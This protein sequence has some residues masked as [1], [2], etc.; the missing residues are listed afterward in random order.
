MARA[1]LNPAVISH[2]LSPTERS[3]AYFLRG[4]S[5]QAQ[6]LFV[7]AATDYAN[8]LEFNPDNSAALY[9]MGGLHQ[10][11]PRLAK[12]PQLVLQLFLRAAEQGHPGAALFVGNA[13]L[14]G[15]G[16][17]KDLQL[18]RNWLTTAAQA[19]VRSAKTLLASTYR[20]AHTETPNPE[21]ARYWYGQA[22]E[23][24]DADA[25]LALG[26]MIRNREVDDVPASAS[27]DYFQR[28]AE[29]GSGTAMT[30]LAHAYMTGRD[31]DEDY[32]KA[33]SWYRKAVKLDAA[34]Q[35]RRFGLHS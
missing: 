23:E 6:G 35:F 10:I 34:G 25:L 33:R 11:E 8:A 27:L 18:A 16:T 29:R 22:I 7:S 20:P 19:G 14:N 5:F 24:G 4:H 21:Q 1:Y 32:A 30:V 26:F 9:A 2:R 12:N 3:G 17:E 28:A 15:E 13:Y 31:V